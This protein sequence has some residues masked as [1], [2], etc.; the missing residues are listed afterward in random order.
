MATDAAEPVAIAVLAKAP[1][2]GFAKTRLVPALGAQRAAELQARLIERAVETAAGAAV[3]PVTL[4]TA[5]DESHALF[6]K[7]RARLGVALARQPDGDLGVRML[8][9]IEAA[10]GS[11]VVI[12][13]DSPALSREHLRTAADLLR[14]GTDVVLFPAEDGGYAL[15]GMRQ[16]QAFLFAAMNWGTAEVLEETRRRLRDRGLRWQEPVTLWD[17]DMPADLDR[18]R[19]AGLGGLIPQ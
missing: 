17:V 2:A 5:P 11:V 12:G 1:V 9:A 10:N 3:G 18:L 16:P 4:W 8:G 7:I 19:A 6:A 15:I 13:T 14:G